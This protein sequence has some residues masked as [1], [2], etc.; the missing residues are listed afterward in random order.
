MYTLQ[1]PSKKETVV[2][3]VSTTVNIWKKGNI[4][5]QDQTKFLVSFDIMYKHSD[6]QENKN[7]Q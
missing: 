3:V 7:V 2:F 5:G 6:S 4:L 1:I